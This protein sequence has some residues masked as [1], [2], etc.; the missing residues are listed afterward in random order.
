MVKGRVYGRL[1]LVITTPFQEAISMELRMEKSFQ[2][3][4]NG[5]LKYQTIYHEGME[6]GNFV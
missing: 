5:Q 6:I 2:Y 1:L 3:Y 4:D